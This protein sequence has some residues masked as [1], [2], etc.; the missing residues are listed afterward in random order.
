LA[1][2]LLSPKSDYRETQKPQASAVVTAALDALLVLSNEALDN[3]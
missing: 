3:F 2:Q 1:T